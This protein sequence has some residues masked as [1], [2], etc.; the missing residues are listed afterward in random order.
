MDRKKNLITL[1]P[2]TEVGLDRGHS[3]EEVSGDLDKAAES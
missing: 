3:T 2:V 1:V